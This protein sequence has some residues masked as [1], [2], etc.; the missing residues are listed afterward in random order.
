MTI[1]I[2]I[3]QHV[4]F[5]DAGCILI[6]I[7]EHGH[8]VSCT[9]LYN[10]EALQD[11]HNIDC[12]IIMGGPMSIHDDEF[13]PWLPAEKK[14]IS[15]AIEQRKK[16]LGICLGAQ[17]IANALGAAVYKSPCEEIGWFPLARAIEIEHHCFNSVA[18]ESFMAFHWHGDTFDIPEQALPIA[19]SAA[20]KHQGFI[21]NDRI[22][23]LQFHLE[24]TAKN[25]KNL[26]HTAVMKFLDI[27]MKEAIFNPH[28]KC[29]QIKNYFLTVML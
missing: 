18:P 23:A 26:S 8:N 25:V 27:Q 7:K 3:L 21:L 9:R 12:L 15:M 2:H 16:V 22:I 1:N 10:N 20:C 19:S 11:L 14:F 4:E 29:L 6:Y 17:L 13:Y 28:N 5:E 24:I